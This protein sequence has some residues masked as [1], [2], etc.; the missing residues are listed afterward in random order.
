VSAVEVR[1]KAAKAIQIFHQ[2]AKNLPSR[3]R[4]VVATTIGS[5]IEHSV[6]VF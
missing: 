4:I 2:S 5:N 6:F 1:I 3:E